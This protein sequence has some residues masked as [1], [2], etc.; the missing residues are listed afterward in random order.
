MCGRHLLWNGVCCTIPCRSCWQKTRIRFTLT[1]SSN[2]IENSFSEPI[3]APFL[4]VDMLFIALAW[5]VEQFSSLF[6][7]GVL[8]DRQILREMNELQDHVKKENKA[9]ASIWHFI[10]KRADTIFTLGCISLVQECSRRTWEEP[11]GTPSIKLCWRY[12]ITNAIQ[13]ALLSC[14]TKPHT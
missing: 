11:F 1:N 14:T 12:W 7:C 5:V 3:A 8:H 10:D 13:S 9:Y 4:K 6:G 2:R